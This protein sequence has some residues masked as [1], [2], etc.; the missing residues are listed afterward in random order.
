MSCKD[1]YLSCLRVLNT[2][3]NNHRFPPA[4]ILLQVALCKIPSNLLL[5][6]FPLP[7]L[8]SQTERHS[9]F[10]PKV[11]FQS[12]RIAYS[13][14][15][16]LCY[17]LL[18]LAHFDKSRIS[19]VIA[20]P[21]ILDRF[22]PLNIP[23]NAKWIPHQSLVHRWIFKSSANLFRI[24]W[25][26]WKIVAFSLPW[27][28]WLLVARNGNKIL[29]LK[30]QPFWHRPSSQSS[31]YSSPVYKRSVADM[32]D[33]IYNPSSSQRTNRRQNDCVSRKRNVFKKTLE[34]MRRRSIGGAPLDALQNRVEDEDANRIHFKRVKFFLG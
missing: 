3:K 2:P 27:S 4:S 23:S 13:S 22:A 16:T 9:Y 29:S 33:D 18:L 12:Q 17:I 15:I 31:R 26:R 10:N 21:S 25:L 1:L 34:M 19:R 20:A 7:Q 28:T 11:S 8:A 32:E 30:F 6:K 5:Q 14:Y 24:V